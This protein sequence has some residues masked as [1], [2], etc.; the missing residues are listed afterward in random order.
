MSNKLPGSADVLVR[1][2]HVQQQEGRDLTVNG[3]LPRGVRPDAGLRT[4]HVLRRSNPQVLLTAAAFRTMHSVR[5]EK[6]SPRDADCPR[7]LPSGQLLSV[8]GAP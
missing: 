4:K 6:A 7:P 5:P 1:H 8:S 3:S 2:P